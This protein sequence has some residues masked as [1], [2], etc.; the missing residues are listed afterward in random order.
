MEAQVKR[1]SLGL[2]KGSLITQIFLEK[3]LKSKILEKSSNKN[4]FSNKGF[5]ELTRLKSKAAQLLTCSLL[6]SKG[7][8]NSVLSSKLHLKCSS[9]ARRLAKAHATRIFCAQ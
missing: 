4:T 8:S 9:V 3:R 7:F 5:K 1:K 6:K 2:R